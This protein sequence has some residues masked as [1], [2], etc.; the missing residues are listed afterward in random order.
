MK[1]TLTS[2]LVL[3]LSVPTVAQDQLA[4]RLPDILQTLET[5]MVRVEGGSFT[6]GCTPEQENCN[7]DEKPTHL[8]QVGS[9]EIGKYE[10][11][12]EL[13]EAVMGANPS[14]FEDCPQCPVE[15]VCWDDIQVFLAKLNAGGGQYRLPSE[16][17]WEYAARGGQ[18]S[19][20]FQYAG[21]N[22]WAAVAWYYE[23]SGNRT[24]PVGQKQANE[25]GL[26]DMS[27]NVREWVQD[28]WHDS[29]DG[30][31]TDGTAW[32]PEDCV[33]RAIRGGSWYGKPS[34]VRS[35]NRFWYATYFHNN[36]LGFRLARTLQE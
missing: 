21:S 36:N 14:A 9:F 25:L 24:N 33:R 22:D 34:Y 23:N 8:V 31:P 26:F 35:A 30:A 5:Q 13:W 2:L 18:Q 17:E 27:G 1:T 7:D 6:I 12:Q 11:T 28:C 16:A 20:G 15:T 19:Q 29:Y 4:E 10:V 3:F 32:E